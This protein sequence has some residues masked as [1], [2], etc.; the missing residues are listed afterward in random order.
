M[1]NSKT[2]K[3][4]LNAILLGIGVI[5]HQIFPAIAGGITPDLTLVM[6]FCIM[7]INSDDY[8]TCLVAGI[9]TGLFTA[10]TTKFPMGQV[11]NFIDKLV[12]VNVMFIL[13]KAI[14]VKPLRD[15]LG[16]QA[17]LV[18]VSIMTVVGTLV[19]GFVFLYSA[20]LM[21]GLP[22]G[23]TVS[24]LFLAV[25]VPAVG[26]NLVA[27]VILFKVISVS[28]KRTNYQLGM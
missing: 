5:L 19:S 24:G 17:E 16:K 12:T 7:V 26:I 27:A 13:M 15:K 14:Y 11:P 25:V 1:K 18:V 21:V 8:K 9:A 22:G 23:L 4:I 2:K 28:I 10:L 3:M 20:L 6:L